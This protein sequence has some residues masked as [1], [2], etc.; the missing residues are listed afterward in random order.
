MYIDEQTLKIALGSL[1]GTAGHLL[2][3]WLVLKHMG[4]T[5][6]GEDVEIDTGNTTPSLKRL[7]SFGSETG[8]FFI[9]FAHTRRYLT[10]KS[11]ASR[12]VIQTN[13]RRWAS[14]GSVVS[15]DPTG[16]LSFPE[17]E[18]ERI[19]V[20]PARRYPFGL[21]YG[22]SGFALKENVRVQVP[23]GAFSVWYGRQSF[24]PGPEDPGTFLIEQ[25][26]ED[27]NISQPERELVFVDDTIRI[28]TEAEP[29]SNETIYS[30]CS[31]Q[32]EGAPPSKTLH[33]MTFNE[34]SKKVNSMISGLDDPEWMR[35]PPEQEL[36]TVLNSGAKA[37][38]LYGPPRTG[39]TRAIDAH[40]H[41]NSEE[42]STI[43]IHDGWSYDNLIQG[44][45]PD[46][47]GNWNWEDGPLK[48]A[49]EAGKKFIVL[50]EINRTEISQAL[51]E[52]FSLLEDAYRGEENSILLRD[53][54]PFYIPRETI[55]LLTMN[56][57][58]KSTEEV[59]DALMGRVA[60]VHFPPRSEDLAAL[61]SY[62]K[63]DPKLREKLGTLFT[64]I[65]PIY[66]LGHGYFAGL[67][68]DADNQDIISY[69]KARIRPVMMNFLGDLKKDELAI[70]D[71]SVDS[72]FNK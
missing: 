68:P 67:P 52:V 24:I 5:E 8:D 61:L 37:I 26:L 42:R 44:L 34:Y 69:Y 49:I 48:L 57:I 12:S 50:E 19:K 40:V 63:I 39:K 46:P 10:M 71:N 38:L 70:I 3:I 23:I 29:L 59:D 33:Q 15:C 18:S 36:R 54:A 16:F 21:G 13:I 6:G 56:T 14:S 20:R 66:P 60:A 64:E 4:M 17:S 53:G 55:F 35:I 28:T 31:T 7:F 65:L 62:K 32:I 11:D 30:L 58:D 2:K 43:Q 72:L 47:S 25:M 51:G 41:R 9:P 27:L 22:E 45:R 1:R